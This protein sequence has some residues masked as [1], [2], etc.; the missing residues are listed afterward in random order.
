M[1][2]LAFSQ[3]RAL[4][5]RVISGLC[6]KGF[7]FGAGGEPNGGGGGRGRKR[8]DQFGGYGS[9]LGARGAWRLDQGWLPARGG[10]KWDSHP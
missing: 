4:S 5:K 10:G 2:T 7:T 8:K 6:F 9:S 3:C 1:G